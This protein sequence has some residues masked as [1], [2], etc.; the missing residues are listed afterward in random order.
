MTGDVIM[1]SLGKGRDVGHEMDSNL[2]E[3]NMCSV[4]YVL[5]FEDK[6]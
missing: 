4:M 2:R 1:S 3:R 6:W 5:N